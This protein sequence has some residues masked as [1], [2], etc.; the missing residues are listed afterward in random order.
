[1]SGGGRVEQERAEG[2][3][4]LIPLVTIEKPAKMVLAGTSMT[5]GPQPHNNN[6]IPQHDD[7]GRR[8][9]RYSRGAPSRTPYDMLPPCWHIY[10][11][12]VVLKGSLL[13]LPTCYD[14]E[15]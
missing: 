14:Y 9:H 10:G 7:Y 8:H 11:R 3:Y 13:I 12:G 6:N 4:I 2:R 1:M 15:S 5:Q